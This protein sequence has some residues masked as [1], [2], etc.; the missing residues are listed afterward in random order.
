[1]LVAV[2]IEVKGRGGA[3]ALQLVPRQLH[4]RPNVVA[5]IY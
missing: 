3:E 2:R 5:S 1:V 4:V